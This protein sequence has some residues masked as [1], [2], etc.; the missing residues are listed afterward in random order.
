[1]LV[2]QAGAEPPRLHP[3]RGAAHVE[4]DLV[5]TRRCAEARRLRKL[6]RIAAAQLQ[7]HRMLLLAVLEQA[8]LAATHQRGAGHHLGVQPRMRRQQPVEIAAVPIG[9]VHH[10]RHGKLPGRG[11]GF[12]AGNGGCHDP[13][14]VADCG[15]QRE[16][17]AF[18]SG[19]L[20]MSSPGALKSIRA[21]N[22]TFRVSLASKVTSPYFSCMPTSPSPAPAPV[23]RPSLIDKATLRKLAASS[24]V[25]RSEA[26]RVD[27]TMTSSTG[28]TVFTKLCLPRYTMDRSPGGCVAGSEYS[29]SSS[30]T[31]QP[32]AT[33]SKTSQSNTLRSAAV[34]SDPMNPHASLCGTMLES[35]QS[36]CFIT[37]SIDES[38]AGNRSR[39]GQP[40]VMLCLLS[41]DR[42]R[43]GEMH[44]ARLQRRSQLKCRP[45]LRDRA[46]KLRFA[47][48]CQRWL[49]AQHLA[50]VGEPSL[51]TEMPEH[52]PCGGTQGQQRD[53]GNAHG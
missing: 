31:H 53:R 52:Q 26:H 40:L 37:S 51:R 7:R 10:R 50:G 30:A 23:I 13:A 27:S 16:P 11:G 39:T 4:V 9:P 1:W 6:A 5:V 28:W 18:V 15:H 44:L 36:A 34:P 25:K 49:D 24:S 32:C 45:G 29:R 19:A 2:H 8:Q 46:D 20:A 35:L 14:I 47:I 48:A 42:H 38:E 21:G 43:T 17:C 41:V 33:S 3:V 22:G 12:D